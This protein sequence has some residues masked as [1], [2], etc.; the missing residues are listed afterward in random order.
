LFS[1]IH[2][3]VEA[4]PFLAG[5]GAI[6]IQPLLDTIWIARF[7]KLYH[8]KDKGLEG[9]S[10]WIADVSAFLPSALLTVFGMVLILDTASSDQRPWFL[11][12]AV[13]A[14]IST[15]A[16]YLLATMKRDPEAKTRGPYSYPQYWLMFLNVVGAVTAFVMK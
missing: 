14:G 4:I 6:L 11:L 3:S 5:I 8:A 10:K 2:A 15:T 12:A 16:V 1:G 13:V 9:A 7:E